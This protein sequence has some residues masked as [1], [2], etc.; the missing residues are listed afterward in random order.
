LGGDT[1]KKLITALFLTLVPLAALAEGPILQHKDTLVQE[2]FENV[3][4][5]LRTKQPSL[6]SGTS[7]QMLIGGGSGNPYFSTDHIGTATNND[8]PTGYVGQYISS[9]TAS[10]INSPATSVFQEVVAITLTAGDWDVSLNSIVE[11]NGAT[12]T[13]CSNGITATAGNNQTGINFGENGNDQ[14]WASSGTTPSTVA[15]PVPPTRV[16]INSTTVY[17][18]KVR[19]I[20]SAGGPPIHQTIISARRVR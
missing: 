10:K 17:Y 5:D 7:G 9:T 18:G 11:K 4:K 16:S 13:R 2:E 6:P 1:V 12:W 19:M 3:Y 14:E 15:L 20:Y 8:A